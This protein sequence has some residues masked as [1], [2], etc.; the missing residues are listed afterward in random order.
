MIKVACLEAE[1]PIGTLYVCVM[2]HLDVLKIAFADVRR[3]E[4]RDVEIYS[5]IQRDLDLKRVKA[6]H[7]YTELVDSTFP[8][9]IILHIESEHVRYDK[10][11][12]ILEIEEGEDVAKILDGQH[13]LKALEHYSGVHFNL[14]VAIFVDLDIEDQ[15]NIFATINLAQ[16][17]VNKSLVYDLFEYGKVRSPA[18]TAHLICRAL[19]IE[20]DSPFEGR[21]KVLGFADD[22]RRETLTQALFVEQLLQYLTKDFRADRDAA[23]R[24]VDLP[25]YS[26]REDKKCFLRPFFLSE[27]DDVIGAIIWNFFKA[28]KDRWPISWESLEKGQILNR[29]TGFIALMRFLRPA[30]KSLDPLIVP[31]SDSF[32]SIFKRI[33]ILDGGF[34][35]ERFVP[36]SSGQVELFKILMNDSGLQNLE[37]NNPMLDL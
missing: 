11:A 31:S 12:G 22:D 23:K 30:Y 29:S 36:G 21:I 19:N 25:T 1:Q 2:G 16:T 17:K 8:T 37:K 3:I 26:D 20:K 27:D 13:R 10:E 9:A 4:K 32:L 33:S 18:R 34:T 5:G 28:V 6:I 14:N 35:K 15:A 24:E 7:S